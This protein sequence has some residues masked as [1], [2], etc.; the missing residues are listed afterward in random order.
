MVFAG[1]LDRPYVESDAPHP[2]NIYGASKQ[3]AERAVLGL[4]IQALV[5]RTGA[6]FCAEASSRFAGRVAQRLSA[7]RSIP[8][9]CDL[10]FSPTYLPDLCN[11]LLDLVIDAEAGLWH[12]THGE[13]MSWADFGGA[14]AE[15]LDLDRRLVRATP[16]AEL[17]R[18][19]H[20]PAR[21]ALGSERGLRM[22]PLSK[23][24]KHYAQALR[25]SQICQALAV[26]P[27]SDPV[28]WV[29]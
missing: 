21:L 2:L 17:G 15:A 28:G 25:E 22:P 9:P 13:A 12:L 23:A 3:A 27:Q 20:H 6:V 26:E 29:A 18:L 19:A 8:A 14:V 16:H 10:I 4:D 24:L 7:G 1:Q 5:V 11:A